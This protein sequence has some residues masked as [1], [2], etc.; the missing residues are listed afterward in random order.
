[1]TLGS[2]GSSGAG[3]H[4]DLVTVV[5]YPLVWSQRVLIDDRAVNVECA[6]QM[7]I[8]TIQFHDPT[9]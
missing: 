6:D 8:P 5:C 4:T 3:G 1:M 7:G 9:N 2:T